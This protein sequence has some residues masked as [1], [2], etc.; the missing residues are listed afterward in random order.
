MNTIEK[1][2]ELKN[3]VTEAVAIIRQLEADAHQSTSPFVAGI[4]SKVT[5]LE[6]HIAN[7]QLWLDKNPAPAPAAPAPVATE[8]A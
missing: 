5:A 8:Q 6:E 1:I 2:V 3:C 4:K 7:H